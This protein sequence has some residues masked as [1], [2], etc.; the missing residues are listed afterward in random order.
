M[1]QIVV[2]RDV[3]QSH[4][5]YAVPYWAIDEDLPSVRARF[6]RLS[7]KFPSKKA[8]ILAFSGS[9]QEIDKVSV[10]DMGDITYPKTLTKIVLQ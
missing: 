10:N 2:V 4:V 1:N 8:S 3:V 9:A 6:K 5:G 7:G